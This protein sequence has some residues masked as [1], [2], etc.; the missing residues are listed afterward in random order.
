MFTL[1]G[2]SMSTAWS[3]PPVIASADAEA[4]FFTSKA[5]HRVFEQHLHLMPHRLQ[6]AFNLFITILIK[7]GR[8]LNYRDGNAFRRVSPP[9]IL[10]SGQVS[11][12]F[13]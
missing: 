5:V 3:F 2:T 13:C 9:F 12:F 6:R 8:T 7:C 10:H 11:P 4:L 1:I